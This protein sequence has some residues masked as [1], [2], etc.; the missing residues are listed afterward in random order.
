MKGMYTYLWPMFEG[1]RKLEESI[2]NYLELVENSKDEVSY[3]S[4]NLHSWHFAYNIAQKR[5]LTKMEIKENL[6]SFRKLISVLEN[7]EEIR[8]STPERWLKE[9]KKILVKC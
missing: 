6:E 3:I 4:I 7:I 5:Y 2:S 1:K 9:H 8:F